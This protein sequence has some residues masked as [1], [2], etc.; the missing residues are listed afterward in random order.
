MNGTLKFSVS[1]IIFS[2]NSLLAE[3][4]RS[5][6]ELLTTSIIMKTNMLFFF[7]GFSLILFGCTSSDN[8]KEEQAATDL[9]ST[10]EAIPASDSAQAVTA[11][12]NF[13]NW[14]RDNMI[15]LSHINLVD[16]SPGK[17]YSVMMD[18]CEKF[19]KALNASG[20]VT[21]NFIHQKRK[22][23]EEKKG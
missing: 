18:S 23:F 12:L 20:M 1:N 17:N 4:C 5:S 13:L 2:E 19:L 21:S 14:Y 16:Q 11:T 10:N 3:D 22:S 7:A 8:A 6:H 9:S 15:R